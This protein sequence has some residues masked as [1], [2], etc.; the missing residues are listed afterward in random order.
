MTHAHDT[1]E[2]ILCFTICVPSATRHNI[3][4]NAYR[5]LFYAVFRYFVSKKNC[6]G[7]KLYPPLRLKLKNNRVHISLKWPTYIYLVVCTSFPKTHLHNNN[8]HGKDCLRRRKDVEV[9]PVC[10]NLTWAD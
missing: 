7:E 4:L 6:C 2:L 9:I 1:S 10:S 8:K 3:H 5:S